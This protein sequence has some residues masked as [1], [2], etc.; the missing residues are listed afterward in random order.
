VRPSRT[1]VAVT[2]I[3][4]VVAVGTGSALVLDVDGDGIPTH[5]EYGETD[6][7]ASDTDGD[8]L[9]DDQES[10]FGSD[11]TK[12]DTDGDGLTDSEEYWGTS[13]YDG[14][15][16][17]SEQV[18]FEWK[19]SDPTSTD[20][21]ADG[22]PDGKEVEKGLDPTAEDSDGDNLSD[23]RE[24]EGPTDPTLADTDGDNLLDG[25]E[26]RGETP[27]GADISEA[28]PLHKD[29]FVHVLYLRGANEE[30]PLNVYAQIRRW[31]RDMP[32]QNPDGETGIR[33]HVTGEQH[34]TRSIDEWVHD[35]GSTTAG[36]SGFMAMRE[37]YNTNTIGAKTGSHFL[38]VIPGDNVPVRGGGNAG[39]TKVSLIRQWNGYGEQAYAR[40][41]VHEMLHN[42]VR[43]VGGQDC[44][45]Q[46]HTCEGFLSYTDDESLSDAAA[47]KLNQNG[48]ADPVYREQ[49]NATDCE[50][51][52]Y[53]KEQ[54][55][56]E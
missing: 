39:G 38:V 6:P 13:G 36:V 8:G 17:D 25:W 19:R 9:D 32:V 48:F 29:A 40:T 53:Y 5:E 33:V 11:P 1:T 14:V 34:T 22:I 52:I 51:T 12:V 16:V 21:D 54:C 2:A 50:E 3:L 31:F 18:G 28:D 20:T 35:D 56:V 4:L 30:L 42:M 15:G 27:K 23:P 24:L 41:I 37:F 26:V 44:N 47:Q 10:A 49:M 55:G 45:G 7:F 43:E 46:M